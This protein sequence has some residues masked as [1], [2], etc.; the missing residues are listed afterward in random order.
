V[1]IFGLVPGLFGCAL[2][3]HGPNHWQNNWQSLLSHN[4]PLAGKIW[5]T[6][7][8]R[9]ISPESLL[10]RLYGKRH[11]LIGEKHNNPDHHRIQTWITSRLINAG[12]RRA[13][14]LEMIRMDQQDTVDQYLKTKPG[15]SLSAGLGKAL[16][17]SKSGWGAWDHYEA[18]LKPALA[19][20]LPIYG[21]NIGFSKMRAIARSGLPALKPETLKALRLGTDSPPMKAPIM[22]AMEAEIIQAHCGMIKPGRAGNFA[23]I[24]LVRDASFANIMEKGR[25]N[26]DGTILIAGAGHVRK[27]R[28]VPMHLRRLANTLPI[29]IFT[30]AAIEVAQGLD[31]PEKY[32]EI[33]G[34]PTPPFDAIWFTPRM[35]D[36]NPCD[37]FKKK[38]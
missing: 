8:N 4:H 23:L 20:N 32:G 30:I 11:I 33:Y 9:F 31:H 18:I 24:Q 22:G 26:T 10:M 14:V 19:K 36:R 15:V 27:D 7:E 17:W 28:G 5:I 13:M 6:S 1:I 12:E 21:A 2:P 29:T 37:R 38:K 16:K 25:E 3:N 34:V 35:S